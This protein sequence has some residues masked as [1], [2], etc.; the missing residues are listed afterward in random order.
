MNKNGKIKYFTQPYYYYNTCRVIQAQCQ[1]Y[2]HVAF[3]SHCA[4]QFGKY[5]ISDDVI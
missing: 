2:A 1:V 3:T 5:R 4:E